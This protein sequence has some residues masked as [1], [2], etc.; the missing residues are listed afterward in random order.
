MG[1]LWGFSGIRDPVHPQGFGQDT[2]ALSLP[3]SRGGRQGKQCCILGEPGAAELGET[4]G[5]ILL[6]GSGAGAGSSACASP[7]DI[8]TAGTVPQ[9]GFA[10]C[11]AP[12]P[13][14][15]WQEGVPGQEGF[16]I[17]SLEQGCPFRHQLGLAPPVQINEKHFPP[18]EYQ[19]THSC[20]GFQS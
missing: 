9:A 10:P 7:G 2:A 1:L 3:S 16:G 6:K 14:C 5:Q 17:P 8:V 19:C 15:Q 11:L 12:I 18:R 20:L 4:G 13:L